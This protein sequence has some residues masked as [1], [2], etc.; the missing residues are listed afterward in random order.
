MHVVAP[1]LREAKELDYYRVRPRRHPRD[2]E[3]A[4]LV[5]RP[6]VPRVRHRDLRAGYRL[7]RMP[8]RHRPRDRARLLLRGR[9]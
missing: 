5:A 9:E 4:G 1:D 6:T 7:S 8:V 2:Q 3:A